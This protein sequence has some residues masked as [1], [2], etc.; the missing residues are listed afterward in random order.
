MNNLKV[1]HWKI[2]V[3]KH[4]YNSD[5]T[6]KEEEVESNKLPSNINYLFIPVEY[7]K[8][9]FTE[10]YRVNVSGLDP[11]GNEIVSE[12]NIH[13]ND[14]NV[15]DDFIS[16]S[17]QEQFFYT[18]C[19]K[20]CIG[21]EYA[22]LI[23]QYKK[24]NVDATHLQLE[25]AFQ[26]YDPIAMTANPYYKYSN[27]NDPYISS[28]NKIGPFWSNYLPFTLYDPAGNALSGIIYGYPKTLGI[29]ASQNGRATSTLTIGDEFCGTSSYSLNTAIGLM[30]G[31]TVPPLNPQLVCIP[32]DFGGGG[33]NPLGDPTPP[34]SFTDFVTFCF[35]G[36]TGESE[37]C[38]GGTAPIV[39]L[40]DPALVA[41]V[42]I[43]DLNDN[44]KPPVHINVAD[45]Y[46]TNN[47]SGGVT[48]GEFTG[49]NVTLAPSLYSFGFMFV[50]KGYWGAIKEVT[51]KIAFSVSQADMLDVN[52]FPTPMTGDN[53]II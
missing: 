33:Y 36:L 16:E 35:N 50:E 15:S 47:G 48:N 25:G 7:R 10:N 23:R 1:D 4:A 2:T 52:V 5:G 32:Q 18:N 49:F 20:T 30:N 28:A 21:R 13:L 27:Y 12:N 17:G 46:N 22:Y 19:T 11:S 9:S 14:N 3:I 41:Q 29:W 44:T 42:V 8:Q 43:T 38:T 53:Y 6:A 31:Y 34:T 24:A 45:L 40:L 37:P 51:T 39:N 26:A